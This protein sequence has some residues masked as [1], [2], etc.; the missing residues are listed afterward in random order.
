MTTEAA[1]PGMAEDGRRARPPAPPGNAE[2]AVDVAASGPADDAAKGGLA[3]RLPLLALVFV[4][5]VVSLAI[6]MCGP[7]L[8][9]PYF[10]TALPIWANQIGLTLFYLSLGYYI[11][12]L[13]AD[14]W[15]RV[16]LLC[17]LTAAA[18]VAT[19]LIPLVSGPVLDWA[20]AGLDPAGN[21]ILLQSLLPVLVLFSVPTTLLGMVSPFAVRLSM[22]R[23]GSAGRSTGQLYALS[24]FGSIAGAFLPVLVL[25][26]AW[27]VRRTLLA[28]CVALLAVSLYGLTL[29]GR[30]V[31][32]SA[33]EEPAD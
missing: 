2:A 24:T 18:A 1:D 27:G 11:G 5:G 25:I 19:A 22:E 12:G 31:A 23:V 8:I 26:P 13:V 7:R 32:A 33:A 15:P 10:G 21:R 17:G 9:A 6:E 14:R 3:R 4:A 16:E 20:V 28:C 29:R 30:A